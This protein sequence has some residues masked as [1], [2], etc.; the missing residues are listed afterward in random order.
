MGIISYKDV[1][2][3]ALAIFSLILPTFL[4]AQYTLFMLH[5]YSLKG[6]D[7]WQLK[8]NVPEIM[9]EKLYELRQKEFFFKQNLLNE[10]EAKISNPTLF[11][12]YEE[13]IENQISKIPFPS[14]EIYFLFVLSF[15]YGIL[16]LIAKKFFPNSKI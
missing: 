4:L 8:K 9:I 14:R 11:K 7:L 3:G 5:T 6:A 15:Y 13:K 10:V 2:R 12:K 16:W 1:I